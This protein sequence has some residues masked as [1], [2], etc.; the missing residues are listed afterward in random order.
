MKTLINYGAELIIIHSA[1][2]FSHANFA[3]QQHSHALCVAYAQNQTQSRVSVSDVQKDDDSF[4][5]THAMLHK[6]SETKRKNVISRR[7]RFASSISGILF[8]FAIYD[9]NC[10]THASQRR[11]TPLQCRG[12]CH[13][14][15]QVNSCKTLFQTLFPR[16]FLR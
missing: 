4:S 8:H 7:T 13:R 14:I 16:P 9:V 5:R 10:V 11:K 12:Q 6:K 1:C 15:A 3:E 2:G